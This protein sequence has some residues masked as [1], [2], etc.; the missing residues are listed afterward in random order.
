VSTG[1]LAAVLLGGIGVL[2]VRLRP[3]W[4]AKYR[5]NFADLHNALLAG[6]HLQGAHLCGADLRGANLSFR[7]TRETFDGDVYTILYPA[8]LSDADL[9]GADL[10]QADLRGAD[11]TGADLR[12]AILNRATLTGARYNTHT[13]W[14]S[15]FDPERH[16]A[17]LVK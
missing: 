15:G 4:V 17:I 5:G 14:P 6:A 10:R 3:Y 11:L 13:R 1:V 7:P 12:G 16:G 8:N 2:G 9:Q